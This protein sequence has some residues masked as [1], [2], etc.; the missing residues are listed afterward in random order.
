MIEDEE[1]WLK[2]RLHR[3][4]KMIGIDH[5]VDHERYE[6]KKSQLCAELS[7]FPSDLHQLEVK[8]PLIY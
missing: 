6:D 8:C 7:I 2:I 1:I 5:D 3:F 4:T